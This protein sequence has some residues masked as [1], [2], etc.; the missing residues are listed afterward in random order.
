VRTGPDL[1]AL[2]TGR[3]RDVSFLLDKLTGRHPVWRYAHLIDR[4][5]IGMAGPF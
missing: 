1:R 4:N 3:G 5:R 2:T